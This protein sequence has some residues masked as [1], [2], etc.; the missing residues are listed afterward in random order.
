MAIHKILSTNHKNSYFSEGFVGFIH[1]SF[2]FIF[3]KDLIQ[4]A[5]PDKDSVFK[6]HKFSYKFSDVTNFKEVDE[7][8]IQISKTAGGT[9]GGAVIGTLVAGPFG[10]LVGGMAGGNKKKDKK[11]SSTFAIEFNNDEWV[12]FKIKNNVSGKLEMSSL[13]N[14]FPQFFEEKE[15]EENPFKADE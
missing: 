10:A 3:S 14:S 7:E 4:L 1:F 12:T 8:V 5:L 15:L 6:T 2:K 13:K 9:I 11:K